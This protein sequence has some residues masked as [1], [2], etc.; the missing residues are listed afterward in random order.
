[1]SANWS[2]RERMDALC[3]ALK[4]TYGSNVMGHGT[5]EIHGMMNSHEPHKNPY[6]GFLP[7]LRG[8]VTPTPDVSTMT[9]LVDT[10]G[11]SYAGH[12]I[13]ESRI[14]TGSGACS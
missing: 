9:S 11:C 14:T 1:M 3:K 7:D 2:D 5:G 10:S 6:P 8:I 13:F 4:A 12:E